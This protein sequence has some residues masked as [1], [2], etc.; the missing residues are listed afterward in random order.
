MAAI[1]SAAGC[2][3]G[4]DQGGRCRHHTAQIIFC[5]S[6]V[7][8]PDRSKNAMFRK[9]ALILVVA[10]ATSGDASAHL[11]GHHHH[12]HS[13]S[14]VVPAYG[15]VA[16]VAYYAAPVVAVYPAPVYRVPVVQP[17]YGYWPRATTIHYRSNL[18]RSV[19][20]V[21]SW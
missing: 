1:C 20:R 15:Y 12:S 14:Y 16:P 18:R 2:D 13:Y 21:R 19:L 17:V 3:G 4:E 11:F 6:I 7:E 9:L 10:A 8:T 5:D